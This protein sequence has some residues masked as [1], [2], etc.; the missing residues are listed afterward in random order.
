CRGAINTALTNRLGDYFIFVFFGLS[1][2][3]GYYFLR[4]RI[5]RSYISLLLLLTAFTKRAQFPFRSWL[6]KAIRAPTPVRSLVHS[7]TLVTAEV[8]YLYYYF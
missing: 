3:R 7:R 4:F 6:P 8:I 1:V 5:F 2:F